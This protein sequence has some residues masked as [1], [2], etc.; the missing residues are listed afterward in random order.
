MNGD[1]VD[2]AT[3]T[4]VEPLGDGRFAMAVPEGWNQGRG[5]FGGLL[6]A[7]MIRAMQGVADADR[8]LRALNAELP[9]AVLVG[10]AE[11]RVSVLR[12]GSG[13]SS[14]EVHLVQDGAVK[15]RASGV[16]GKRRPVDLAWQPEAPAMKPW[17]D[18]PLTPVGALPPP[19]IRHF[20]IRPTVGQPFA[21]RGEPLVEGWVRPVETLPAWGAAE[22]AAFADTY[23]PAFFPCV[24]APRPA[25]TVAFGLH[26][27]EAAH[28][29]TMEAPLYYRARA[30]SVGAGFLFEQRELWT[31]AGQL[32]AVNPQTITIIK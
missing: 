10:P 6:V 8:P 26:L 9:S 5:A 7:A 14:L 3:A 2:F 17:S 32:V 31:E 1:S 23:W 20:E 19:F 22:V 30:L 27:T 12:R 24:T 11:L 25:A 21:G 28:E 13:L 29:L 18:V 15:S 16:F 4:R